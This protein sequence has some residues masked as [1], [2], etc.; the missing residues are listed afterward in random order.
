M[1]TIANII[2]NS[3]FISR[4]NDSSDFDNL[5]IKRLLIQA[6]LIDMNSLNFM[7]S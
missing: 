5:D 3:T 2:G 4:I 1:L 6:V 7:L